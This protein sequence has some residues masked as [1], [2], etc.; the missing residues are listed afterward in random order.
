MP[1][2]NR[3]SVANVM[4]S[5]ACGVELQDQMLWCITVADLYRLIEIVNDDYT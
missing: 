4:E 1:E 2:E 3:A 5:F